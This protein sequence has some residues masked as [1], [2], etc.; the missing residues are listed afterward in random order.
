MD[1]SIKTYKVP[2]ERDEEGKASYKEVKLDESNLIDTLTIE[3]K[4]SFEI[5]PKAMEV[6]NFN[7]SQLTMATIDKDIHLVSRRVLCK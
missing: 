7:A 6:N 4:N 5:P 2:V 3:I 1:F